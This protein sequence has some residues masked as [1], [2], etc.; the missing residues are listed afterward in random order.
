[1]LGR[2]FDDRTRPG[3]LAALQPLAARVASALALPAIIAVAAAVRLTHTLREPF[4]LNDGG[5]FFAMVRDIQA[6][7][8]MLPEYTRYN[9]GDIPFAYPPLSLYLAALLDPVVPGSLETLFRVLPLA[10]SVLVVWAFAHLARAMLPGRG[11]AWLAALAFALAPGSFVWLLMG[12]GL[13]RSFGLV[14]GLLAIREAWLLLRADEFS[15]RRVGATGVLLAV[16]AA[17]HL[18]AAAFACMTFVL[19]AAASPRR[20][21][22]R[23]LAVSAVG[24][25]AAAPWWGLV[26]ARHGL[27][28]FIAARGEGGRLIEDGNVSIGWIEYVLRNPLFTG[29]PNFPIIGV[30][31]LAGAAW[32]VA[33]RQ[34]FLPAWWL[35]TMVVG[36]RAFPTFTAVP[37]CLLAGLALGQVMRSALAVAREREWR[38][39]PSMALP[40]IAV[41]VFAIGSLAA[42][43]SGPPL[44]DLRTLSEDDRA[45]MAWVAAETESDA[46][47]AV[48]P[49]YRWWADSASEWFP[50]LGERTSV[51]TPHGYEWVPGE[52]G[53]REW[54][55]WRLSRCAG[56]DVA[57]VEEALAKGKASVTHLYL[58]SGCCEGLKE[59]VRSSP[60]YEV[61][62]DREVLVARRVTPAPVDA[63]RVS[64]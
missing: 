17:T 40:A 26:V 21:G 25:V 7:G 34:W 2:A 35:S 22:L 1:M 49:P 31:G 13:S 23:L 39:V 3:W 38:L 41:I 63:A 8:Y 46:A 30:L 19:M 20:N 9:G 52:F 29:E 10:G 62:Y 50:A 24:A 6:A 43:S 57:C 18:E 42:R 47:F 45:A 12:G 44:T 28:P 59:S 53:H 27:W 56:G 15:R 58:P 48:I 32:A 54:L 36:M 14:F 37:I 4:P 5:L 33:H 60:A 64:R 55:H 11:T 51:A 16:A 61:I